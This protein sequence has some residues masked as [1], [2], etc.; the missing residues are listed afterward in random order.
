VDV[1]G[2]V[3]KPLSRSHSVWETIRLKDLMGTRNVINGSILQLQRFSY[4]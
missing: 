4:E 2:A 1:T 3:P